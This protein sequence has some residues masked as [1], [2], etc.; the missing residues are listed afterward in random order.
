MGQQQRRIRQK[1]RQDQAEEQ[2]RRCR[3]VGSNWQPWDSRQG[4]DIRNS[5][6]PFGGV[7]LERRSTYGTVYYY[8][9]W[10]ALGDTCWPFHQRAYITLFGLP[11]L[12][13]NSREIIRCCTCVLYEKLKSMWRLE[14]RKPP[15]WAM[16]ILILSFLWV[17]FFLDQY[18]NSS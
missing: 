12:T 9:A 7:H 16:G 5:R 8:V 10:G 15:R 6:P 17:V 14:R 3:K 2:E 4:E 13:L 18:K 11:L 1:E